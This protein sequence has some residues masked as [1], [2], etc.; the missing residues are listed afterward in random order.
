M[1]IAGLNA[2]SA[3]AFFAGGAAAVFFFSACL[4][5]SR[6]ESWPSSARMRDSYSR[7]I[8][9]ICRASSAA[10]GC[11]DDCASAGAAASRTPIERTMAGRNLAIVDM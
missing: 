9:W 1:P 8:S 2:L 6:F 7:F 10:V 5:F 11:S 3:L 4:S